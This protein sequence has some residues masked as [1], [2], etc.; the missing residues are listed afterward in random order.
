ML[1]FNANSIDP[2]QMPHSLASDLDLYS[3][4]VSLLW[5]TKHKWVKCKNPIQL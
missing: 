1:A 3:L 2:D 4:P 5:D